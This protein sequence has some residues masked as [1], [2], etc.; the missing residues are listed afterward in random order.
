MVAVGLVTGLA[1]ALT[2]T[3][4]IETLL[5][6]I[7]P[8]DVTSFACVSLVLAIIGLAA[9]ALPAYRASRVDP[10]MVLRGE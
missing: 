6:G 10:T 2:V 3:R 1:A 4:L 9:A 7:G 8:R 5:F